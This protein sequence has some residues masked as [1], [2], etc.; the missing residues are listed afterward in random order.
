MTSETSPAHPG[1]AR[2]AQPAEYPIGH[3]K[4]YTAYPTG[5]PES[6]A[7][8]HGP[9]GWLRRGGRA[10]RGNDAGRPHLPADRAALAV[11]LLATA[12]LYLWGLGA[13]GWA[14]SF[15]SAAAQAGSA[16]WKAF[17]FGSS[18]AANSITVDKTPLA[19]WPMG[20]SVRIFGLSSWSILV[21]QAL[22]GVGAVW[23]LHATVRR[24][25]GSSLAALTAGATMAL[26]PVAVL[27]F[28]FNNPDA[29]LVLLLVAS[30]YATL[31]AVEASASPTG[32][33]AARWLALAGVLVGLA[34]LAKMLQAF[35]VIPPLVLV[36]GV[37]AGVTWRRKV[38]HLLAAAG[39]LVVSAGW[40][41]AIV[42]LWPAASR[43]YI[44]GSQH[45][46]IL[47]L[48]LGYNGFGRLDGSET[49][50]VGGGGVGGTGNSGGQWGAT[51]L[52]R[53]FNSE[54]GSQ[55]AWLLPAALVLGVAALFFTRG[56]RPLQAGLTLW[57]GWLVVTGLTFS[58][59]AGIFHPYYTVA[60]APAIGAL[61]GIG[62]LV[63]WQ[64]RDSLV[65][66]GAL[67]LTTALTTALAFEL[68]DRDA[69]WHPWLK[70]VVATVG[71]AAAMLV[72]A[73]R[74]LPRRIAVA[75]AIAAL[76]AGLTG[77]AAYSL[78]TASTPHTGSIPSAGPAS[79]AGLGGGFGGFGGTPPT[80]LPTGGTTN[81]A[82]Q[83][84]TG[85]TGT[86]QSNRASAGGLLD[87]STSSAA[88]NALLEADA[89]SY[90][91]AAAAV[92]SNSAAGYQLAT[93]Q[94][95]MAIGGFNGSDPSPTLAQF[96]GW[97]AA[98]RIHYFIAGGGSLGGG[99][100]GQ[101]TGG[102]GG[103]GTASQITSWVESTY[104]AKT[105]DGVT[106]YDLT[107]GS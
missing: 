95:V 9:G 20:L 103:S 94:P 10:G 53:M 29:M 45:N 52:L 27:M 31:R 107:T 68:L 75:V 89:S 104:T 102:Q 82:G 40:W 60:L 85:Q 70:Y 33:R 58:L 8:D 42:S 78:A 71:F 67:G 39:G 48:T 16:S 34:F 61:V 97:V 100:G 98:G 49:G 37:F 18:D 24:T 23:L 28:R 35:L 84:G 83:T 80:G 15:Y 22:E 55:V 105:V 69:S 43:P 76:L 92:G 32:A 86:S 41:I 77:P 88:L 17:F 73:A 30:A 3:P 21:P 7:Q 38:L 64:R 13:S 79:A 25:T 50:S 106:L 91:W 96:K 19:L 87:G 101:G 57:L 26:T 46:S 66:T 56:R 65:A 90:T 62:A 59:M 47:E 81:R 14:N 99:F 63:L 5:H 51:G 6:P 36:Y 11:L 4:A 54:L 74:H 2:D 1:L 93:Q 72:V 12:L 44:G